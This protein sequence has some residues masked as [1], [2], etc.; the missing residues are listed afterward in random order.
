MIK[1]LALL[2]TA[3]ILSLST[4]AS[5][6]EPDSGV[7][8]G[9][10]VNG[11][12]GSSSVT[13]QDITLKAYQ[14]DNER[15]PVATKT[16]AKGKFVFDGLATDTSYSYQVTLTF[17]QAEYH[18]EEFSFNKGETSKSVEV[19]VYDST[20]SDEAIW[21]ATGHTIIYIGQGNL[22]V[23]EYL[24][25][26][27]E[28]DRT[29]I[30]SR[31]AGTDGGRETLRFFL[32]N[33]ASE[34]QLAGDLMGR[35]IL[36]SE[37][38]LIYI[39][40]VLPGNMEIAYT[41]RV[42]YSSGTYIYSQ[43]VNYPTDIFNLMVQG[44]GPTV[45]SHQLTTEGLID[46]EGTLF[47][48]LLGSDFTPGETLVVHLSDLPEA[49]NQAAALWALLALVVTICGFGFSYLLR[50]SKPQP[51]NLKDDFNQTKYRLLTEMAQLDDDF[52]AGK[53]QEENYRRLRATRKAQLVKL[54]QRPRE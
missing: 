28:S 40:P 19:T 30:G 14:S 37:G 39:M 10:L 42:N 35:C 25:F 4:P 49:N 31:G 21:V 53:I 17:Q 50:K 22:L 3:F 6:A 8:Y 54:M 12:K 27:N 45:T 18:S 7:I 1:H 51:V 23:K 43:R 34:L 29:Y 36:S 44:E 2:V 47:N 11:T 32:P 15:D 5:A 38:D 46:F 26:V 52:E 13:H 20:T 48:H 41:Y 16:D 24:L 33:G 9:Q